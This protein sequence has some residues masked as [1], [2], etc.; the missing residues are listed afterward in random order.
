MPIKMTQFDKKDLAKEQ[1]SDMN[2]F[3]SIYVDD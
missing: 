1:S 3:E 2:S